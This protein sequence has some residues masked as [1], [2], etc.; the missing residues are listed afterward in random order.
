MVAGV[1]VDLFQ[2]DE[3]LRRLARLA[4]ETE[5]AGAFQEGRS[6]DEIDAE[7]GKTDAGK[8]WLEELEKIKDPWF[9]MGTGDGLYHYFGSWN[10]D[11]S[12]PYAVADRAHRGAPGRRGIDRP[13]EEIV[14][15]RDRIASEYAGAAQR[16][17][18]ADVRGAARPLAQGLPLRR[19]A[20][21]LLRLLVPVAVLQQDPRVRR[22]AGRARLPR[23]RRGH[24][25][26]LSPRGDGGPRGARAHLGDRRGCRSARIAGRRSRQRRKELLE[27]LGEWTPP[28]ALGTMP[29]AVND[30]MIVMLWGITK[31]RLEAWARA[32]DG[33]GAELSRLRGLPRRD[34][35][36][37]PAWSG[38]WRA[39]RRRPRRRDPGLHDHLAV[40]GADLQQDQGDRHRHRR[41]HVPRGDRLPRVR[42]A[43]RGR[44][45]APPPRGSRPARCSGSTAPP[46]SCRSS[47]ATA[48]AADRI[49]ALAELRRSD[50][51]RFGAKSASLGELIA[52]GIPVPPGFALF[53]GGL[54]GRG[55]GRRPHG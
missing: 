20:Q 52:G 17:G 10:D 48:M 9:N 49:R 51:E 34:R 26:A 47:T 8:S 35:G 19:G 5:V 15:E 29:E 25:P 30:P 43:G 2:P 7:L 45:R 55:R 27:K 44:D 21:V 13:T 16:G 28:P 11:P 22:R 38:T 39:A 36:D 18:P 6:P 50:E 1:D 54:P 12:I 14:S 40:L 32:Q 42:A 41:D 53:G 23:R 4:I 31:E 3:E 46:G 37:R 33:D 24:L